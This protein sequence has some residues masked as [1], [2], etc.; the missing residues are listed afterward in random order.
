MWGTVEGN[1][2]L[3]QVV[4][5]FYRASRGTFAQFGLPVPY[6]ERVVDTVLEHARD[7]RLFAP[8]RQNACN[9]L[10]VAHPLWLAGRQTDHRS[11]EVRALA[12]RLLGDLLGHWTDGQGFGFQAPHPRDHGAAADRAGAAGHGDVAGDLLAAGGPGGDVGAA[13]VPAAGDP[14]AGAGAASGVSPVRAGGTAGAGSACPGPSL[15][16]RP[17]TAAGEKDGT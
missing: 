14:P 7:P 6:P 10:D 1:G 12:T 3:L 11:A 15:R 13:R 16:V 4:N 8:E 17:A 5:G 9:V 2:G